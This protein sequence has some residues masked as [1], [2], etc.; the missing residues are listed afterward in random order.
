VSSAEIAIENTV[1]PAADATHPSGHGRNVITEQRLMFRATAIVD[2]TVDW[3]DKFRNDAAGDLLAV[4]L[5]MANGS[6]GSVL[7]WTGN[8]SLTTQPAVTYVDG[9]GYIQLEGEFVT[10]GAAAALTLTQS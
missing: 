8:I 6:I 7:T 9:I 2:A 3:R 5:K 1:T 4:S 10:I